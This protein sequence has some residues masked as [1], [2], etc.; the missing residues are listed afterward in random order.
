MRRVQGGGLTTRR[1]LLAWCVITLTSCFVVA[2]LF[3]AWAGFATWNSDV[4]VLFL[5]VAIGLTVILYFTFRWLRR[6]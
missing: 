1:S 3:Y 6:T 2:S 5:L 4:G